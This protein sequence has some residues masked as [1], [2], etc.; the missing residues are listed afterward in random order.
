M[1][2]D[3]TYVTAS[4]VLTAADFHA[5]IETYYAGSYTS[6]VLWDL[7]TADVSGIDTEEVRAIVEHT[8]KFAKL[9]QGGKTAFVFDDPYHFGMGRMFEAYAEMDEMAFD[10]HLFRN[11]DDARKWLGIQD[12]ESGGNPN[13]RQ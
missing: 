10:I 9:R 13:G 5:W 12:K 7:T 2:Q 8:R 3:L 1:A 11:F 6:F 4:G